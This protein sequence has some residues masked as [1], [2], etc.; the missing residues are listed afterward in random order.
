MPIT[1]KEFIDIYSS[2]EESLNARIQILILDLISNQ[3]NAIMSG[4]SENSLREQTEKTEKIF[5]EVKT[6]KINILEKL[7]DLLGESK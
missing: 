3:F 2:M 6:N 1:K 5:S 7:L 4:N